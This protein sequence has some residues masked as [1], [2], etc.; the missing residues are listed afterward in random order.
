MIYFSGDDRD[1]M[2]VSIGEFAY[3]FGFYKIG[4]VE[5]GW[6]IVVKT[7]KHPQETAFL[8]TMMDEATY[9]T[10]NNGFTLILVRVFT[11]HHVY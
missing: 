8:V 6:G 5:G 3:G 11:K 4:D 10:M 7:D 2:F 1:N 9:L